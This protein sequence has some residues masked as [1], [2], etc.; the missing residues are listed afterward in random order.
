MLDAVSGVA[1]VEP[2]LDATVLDG[3]EAWFSAK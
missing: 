3:H 2:G 1:G